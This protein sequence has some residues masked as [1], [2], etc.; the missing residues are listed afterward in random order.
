MCNGK[1]WL[2]GVLCA[3]MCLTLAVTVKQDVR[4]EEEGTS[5]INIV[6]TED[7]Q[8]YVTPDSNGEVAALL[9]K[10]SMLVY[11]GLEGSYV[12]VNY[13]GTV[14]YMEFQ[15]VGYSVDTLVTYDVSYAV[16]SE[17]MRMLAAMIQCE[18]GN[19]PMEGQIAVGAVIMNR[20]KSASYPNTISEVIYQPSQ[21]G[22]AKSQRF[23]D[24]VA[25]D[26]IK[27]SCREAARQASMGVDNVGGALHFKRAG[28]REGIVIG[29]HVFY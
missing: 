2:A 3:V 1:K 12:K 17:E 14:G 20:V 24:L 15:Y 10:Y 11:L 5:G 16:N 7:T 29:N 26:T 28:S 18:A 13:N 21:F 8:L 25:N 27:D 6:C 4:A 19:Q 9:P 22:P 23:A